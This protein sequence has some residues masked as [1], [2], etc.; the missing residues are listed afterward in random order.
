MTAPDPTTAP[1]GDTDPHDPHSVRRVGWPDGWC[2]G[3]RPACVHAVP[4]GSGGTVCGPTGEISTAG[5][6]TDLPWR[7]VRQEPPADTPA[8]DVHAAAEA[9]AEEALAP[10]FAYAARLRAGLAAVKARQEVQEVQEVQDDQQADAPAAVSR[11][12]RN[13]LEPDGQRCYGQLTFGPDDRQAQCPACGAWEGRFAPPWAADQPEPESVTIVMPVEWD[14]DGDG[15]RTSAGWVMEAQFAE[16]QAEA[17]RVEDARTRA[18]WV[19]ALRWEADQCSEAAER[20]ERSDLRQADASRTN[21]AMLVVDAHRIEVGGLSPW[22]ETPQRPAAPAQRSGTTLT[23]PDSPKMLRETLCVAQTALGQLP[24]G[25]RRYEHIARLGRLVDECDRHRPLGANGKHGY[26][27]RCTATC[28]CDRPAAPAGPAAAATTAPGTAPGTPD[29]HSGARAGGLDLDAIEARANA[30]TPGPWHKEHT[31]PN[32]LHGCVTIGD[33]GWVCA[34]PNAPAYDEDSDEGHADAEFVAHART[35]V[36]ALVAL[37]REL[38]RMVQRQDDEIRAIVA[39]T[40]VGDRERAAWVPR[41]L[42]TARD[43][44]AETRQGV[45]VDVPDIM[46]ELLRRQRAA[47]DAA[48]ADGFKPH[49]EDLNP[50]PA[51][52]SQRN[53]EREVDAP[54]EP[55]PNLAPGG[56]DLATC[57]CQDT[58]SHDPDCPAARWVLDT[59][60]AVAAGSAPRCHHCGAA[61]D[62]EWSICPHCGTRRP[63]NPP[64]TTTTGDGATPQPSGQKGADSGVDSTP[65]DGPGWDRTTIDRIV[66]DAS[67]AEWPDGVVCV[68]MTAADA[69]QL[70]ALLAAAEQAGQIGG[71]VRAAWAGMV[72]ELTADRDRW[73]AEAERAQQRFQHQCELGDENAMHR[74]RLHAELKVARDELATARAE[75]QRLAAILDPELRQEIARDAAADALTWHGQPGSVEAALDQLA[76]GYPGITLAQAVR[77]G[78]ITIPT[79]AAEEPQHG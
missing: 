67:P 18:E 40:A 73:K 65:G 39:G 37:V 43:L 35:D 56:L 7:S 15:W 28:G 30:A 9:A 77:T 44:A 3:I 1:C 23:V 76:D 17:Q 29:A 78:I 64:D 57:R 22:R 4:D 62:P 72:Q 45:P 61:P 46:R 5:G 8:A 10:A 63:D 59:A 55:A 14:H 2:G 13:E 33:H 41:V 36:P 24:P 48:D 51:D 60:R 58:Q 12:C 11:P 21:A 31:D 6:T 27:E 68:E 19:A 66:S 34:G 54:S 42:D 49:P 52:S 38:R 74:L 70:R 50:G 26:G 47:V 71:A 16:M 32:P 79:T 69:D 53:L 25:N 75:V 20:W